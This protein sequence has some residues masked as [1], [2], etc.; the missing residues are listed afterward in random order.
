MLENWCWNKSELQEMSC[1]YTR[2]EPG[3]LEKWTGEHKGT[4]LPDEHIPEE[5]LDQLIGGRNFNKAL[6]LLQQT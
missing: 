1:H 2:A 5:L 4:P 3:C 6:A